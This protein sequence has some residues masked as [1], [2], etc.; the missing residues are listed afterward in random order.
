MS[1]RAATPLPWEDEQLD[2]LSPLHF[3][4]AYFDETLSAW[5]LS[6]F[7]DVV[8]AFRSPALS[9]AGPRSTLNNE[10]LNDAP[11][12]KMRAETAEALSPAILGGWRNEISIFAGKLLDG[13]PVDRP[14]DL[15]AEY[16]RPLCL[17]IAT[18]ATGA[19]DADA[20][21]LAQIAQ[22][23]SGAAAEPFDPVLAQR[24][25]DADAKLRECFHS[26]PVPLRE[27]GFVALSQTL[28]HLLARSWFALLKSPA[29][30]D[31]LH[32]DPDLIVPAVEELLRYAGLT[33]ILFRMATSDVE[34]NGNRIQKGERI[35]LR[36]IAANRDP[37]AFGNPDALNFTA[38]RK[39]HLALGLGK[40]GCVGAPLI[41][42][43][44]N[45]AT[46]LLVQRYGAAALT[47]EMEW[48]GGSGFCFP[49][50]LRVSLGR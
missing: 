31:R 35:V 14:V 21:T 16:A 41:R 22:T 49:A 32:R 36:I 47:G 50:S 28:C 26:G 39:N 23:V 11:R 30:W 45:T 15:V 18:M 19:S 48:Q 29:E 27:S 44:L 7:D 46:R 37:G 40:H 10:N 9:Q 1:F 33:R 3:D 42:L 8:A 5:V 43:A 2:S 4:D 38:F 17:K 6:R 25:K 34:I 20:E 13:L 24:A 12:L